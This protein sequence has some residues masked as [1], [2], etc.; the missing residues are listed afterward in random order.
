MKKPDNPEMTPKGD[1]TIIFPVTGHRISSNHP[2]DFLRQCKEHMQNNDLPIEGDWKD[3]MFDLA[4]QQNPNIPCHDVDEPKHRAAN[5]T[6]VW[7]FLTVLWKSFEMGAKQVPVE[8]QERRLNICKGC[9]KRGVVSCSFG[10]GK[11]AEV[12]STLAIGKPST[13]NHEMHKQHC[14]V[15]SCE[16]TTMSSYPL[17]ILKS[18]DKEMNFDGGEY[19]DQCW[20]LENR[21]LDVA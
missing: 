11:L 16:L 1:W 8:E 21:P 18:V 5:G 19:W 4:C 2:S 13:I 15:C 12:L 3:K 17:E 10:C 20:K 7:R 6:D 14:L 9:P